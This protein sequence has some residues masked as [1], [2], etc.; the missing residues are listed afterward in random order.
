MRASVVFTLRAILFCLRFFASVPCILAGQG[1]FLRFRGIFRNPD[2]LSG[3]AV[4]DVS[5]SAQEA[6]CA[7]VDTSVGCGTD[8]LIENPTRLCLPSLP[9]FPCSVPPE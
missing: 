9:Y 4:G 1:N 6:D 3:P 8:R 7:E 2:E 5:T